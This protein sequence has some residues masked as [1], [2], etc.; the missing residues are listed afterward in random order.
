MALRSRGKR[1]GAYRSKMEARIVPPLLERGAQYE[2][3]SLDYPAGVKKYTPDLVLPNGIVVE[4]KG[5]FRSSDRT[6]LLAVKKEHPHLELRLVLASPNQKL[7]KNSYTTQA[8]WCNAHGFV[9]AKND[10]PESWMNEGRFLLSQV[11]IGM[12]HMRKRK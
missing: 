3:I 11:V 1:A 7:S 9:W 12:S 10:V 5:W 6:K 8:M 4:I 2:P